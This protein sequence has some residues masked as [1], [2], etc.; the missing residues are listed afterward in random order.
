MAVK[1]PDNKDYKQYLSEIR[2][3]DAE[4]R[5]AR[6]K[7]WVPVIS[8][9]DHKEKHAERNKFKM[10]KEDILFQEVVEKFQKMSFSDD[11]HNRGGSKVIRPYP[12]GSCNTIM[13]GKSSTFCVKPKLSVK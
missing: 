7:V 9:K 4:S 10:T 1:K 3:S 6:G 8:K 2:N 11:R 5:R 13:A 12:S